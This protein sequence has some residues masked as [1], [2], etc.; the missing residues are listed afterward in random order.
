MSNLH[1]AADP[2]LEGMAEFFTARV[3]GYDPHMLRNVEGCKEAYPLLASLLP[4]DSSRMLD[5]GCGTGL[6]LDFIFQRFP[7]IKVT[8]IDLTKS[9]LSALEAKHPDKDLHLICGDY[10]STDFGKNMF[11]C[12]VS[13]ES[14]HHFTKDS[15]LELYRRLFDA[16]MPGGCYLECDYMVDTQAEEDFF[17]AEIAR[18]RKSQGIA[19]DLFVHYDTPCTIENQLALLRQAGFVQVEHRF[20]KGGTSVI[21]AQK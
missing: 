4:P 3:D 1:T 16:L 15:K 8:G 5:L 6:E 20:R 17:F 13:V 12:A 21:V 18:L 11:D 14:L 10:F 2:V 7:N 19:D 9:M